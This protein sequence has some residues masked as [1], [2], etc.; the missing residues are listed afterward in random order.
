MNNIKY[1]GIDAATK[2]IHFW[3]IGD[4]LYTGRP[5]EDTGE[6]VLSPW[7]NPLPAVMFP[8]ADSYRILDSTNDKLIYRVSGQNYLADYAL[9]K[10][11]ADNFIFSISNAGPTEMTM[12][13]E[14]SVAKA[15]ANPLVPILLIAAAYW[16][17][18]R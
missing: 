13:I 1:Y 4:S 16:V 12:F 15:T 18:I 6:W 11:G 2:S 3:G 17:F 9:T 7:R 5:D 10:F 8:T 14:D